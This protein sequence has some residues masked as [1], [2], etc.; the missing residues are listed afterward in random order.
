MA[1]IALKEEKR[2]SA[3]E[4]MMKA[5]KQSSNAMNPLLSNFLFNPKKVRFF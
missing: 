1:E 3:S 5:T 4:A 2:R